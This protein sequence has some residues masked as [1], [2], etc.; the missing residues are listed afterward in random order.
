VEIKSEIYPL[1]ISQ[2]LITIL[3]DEITKAGI[4]TNTIKNYVIINFSDPVHTSDDEGY[5]PVEVMV[6]PMG[7]ILYITEF[8]YANQ[9]LVKDLDFDFK[10][11]LFHQRGQDCSMNDGVRLF[12]IFQSNFCEHYE[13]GVFKVVATSF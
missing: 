10:L 4:D 12:R 3:S 6:S 8:G 9:E 5:H 13:N 2:K 7:A 1:S 11:N